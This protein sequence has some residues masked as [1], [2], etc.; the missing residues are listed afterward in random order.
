MT[1][2]RS[3]GNLRFVVPSELNNA[4]DCYICAKLPWTIKSSCSYSCHAYLRIS[5]YLSAF[6]GECMLTA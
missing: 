3:W 4:A 1:W 6:G 5:T 2:N